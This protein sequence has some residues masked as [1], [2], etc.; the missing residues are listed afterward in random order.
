MNN[1]TITVLFLGLFGITGL[2][3]HAGISVDTDELT[4]KRTDHRIVYG[5]PK[6]QTT[7]VEFSDFECPFCAR[8]HTTIKQLVDDSNGT[9]NWEYRH[10]PLGFHQQAEVA[11]RVA[12][13]VF[14]VDGSDRF[15]DFSDMVFT[16]TSNLTEAS[17]LAQAVALGVPEVSLQ[18]CLDTN[19]EVPHYIATDTAA[20]QAFGGTGTPFSL[21]V[22]ADG[23]VTPVRGAL[24]LEQWQ[25]LLLSK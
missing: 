9:I 21:I 14:R 22:F 16:D 4:A 7:I 8:V 23:E 12:E 18:E 11:A 24:P 5:E 13:C 6:A 10:F 3:W 17:L 19:E 1:T 2:F 20:A 15:W 25:A